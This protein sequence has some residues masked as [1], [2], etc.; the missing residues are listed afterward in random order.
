M[1]KFLYF[2]VVADVD[3]DDGTA[4]STDTDHPTSLMIPT[5]KIISISPNTDSGILIQFES[6]RNQPA[7]RAGATSEQ[8]LTDSV[9]IECARHTQKEI[10]ETIIQAINSNQLY[11]DGF[12]TVF[13]HVTTNLANEAVEEIKIHPSITGPFAYVADD[14]CTAITVG[15]PQ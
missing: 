8:T 1:E 13:D 10:I 11:T 12:I 15:D 14:N 5:S 3:N 2:R 4:K 6:V 7:L 9:G